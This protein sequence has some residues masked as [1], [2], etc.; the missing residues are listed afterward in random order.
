MK[1]ERSLIRFPQNT[2]IKLLNRLERS[3]TLVA[4]V[5]LP[6]SSESKSLGSLKIE[7]EKSPPPS[8]ADSPMSAIEVPIHQISPHISHGHNR[9]VLVRVQV[10]DARWQKLESNTCTC[11]SSRTM[12]EL[13]ASFKFPRVNIHV[14]WLQSPRAEVTLALANQEV[15]RTSTI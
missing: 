12:F 2:Y 4:T 3:A 11:S 6:R 9:V 5:A 14:F 13:R 8:P 7:R 15:L 10:P 1:G